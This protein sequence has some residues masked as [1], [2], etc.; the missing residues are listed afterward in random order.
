MPADRRG[1]AR[2]CN[3]I[4][5][6][7]GTPATAQPG[8]WAAGGAQPPTSN[9]GMT[10]QPMQR[11]TTGSGAASQSPVDNYTYDLLQALTSRLEAIE[12]Y[13]LYADDEAGQ[14]GNLFEELAEQDRQHAER[15]LEA[16]RQRLTR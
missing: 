1:P 14:D 16:L 2:P 9:E 11:T 7:G 6:G 10:M 5:P 8:E 12:A 4:L 13:E 15:L 3:L